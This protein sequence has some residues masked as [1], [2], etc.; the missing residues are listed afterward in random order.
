MWQIS[1]ALVLL[2]TV[3]ADNVFSNPPAAGPTQDYTTNDIW[4]LDSIQTIRFD[5]NF[6][7][8]SVVLWQQDLS[9]SSATPVET[10]YGTFA[11]AD[12]LDFWCTAD[13]R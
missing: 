4:P 5:I 9:A 6:T 8:F 11:F 13:L 7:N 1:L 10:V 12:R 3:T 2:Q